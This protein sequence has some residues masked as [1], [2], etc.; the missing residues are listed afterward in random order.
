M[1]GP[2]PTTPKFNAVNIQNNAPNI[3]TITAS[4]RRQVK[5]QSSQYWTFTA[6]YPPLTRAEWAPVAAF[7]VKQ[8]GAT[9]S[10]QIEIPEYSNTQGNLSGVVNPGTQAVGDTAIT[11]N[12]GSLT[13]TDSLKAGDFVRFSNHTKVYMVLDDVDFTS[14]TATMNIEPGLLAAVSASDTLVYNNVDFTVFLNNDVQEFQTG[15][16]GI[17]Q[18]EIELREAI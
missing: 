10:F 18:Y 2:Y 14:G 7:V 9:E 13:Q 16:A 6:S 17:V 15:L 8:R 5:S 4:G 1:S 12:Q 11:L 3:T